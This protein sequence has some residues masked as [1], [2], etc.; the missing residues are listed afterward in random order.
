MVRTGVLHTERYRATELGQVIDAQ[1]RKRRWVADRVGISESYLSR[2]IAG[3]KTI[4]RARGERIGS[5]LGV[6]FFVLFEV[7]T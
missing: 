6:P 1:G 2:I 5:L 3:E 7:A 4:D